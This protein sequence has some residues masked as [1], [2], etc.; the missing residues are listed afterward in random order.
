M[1]NILCYE[2]MASLAMIGLTAGGVLNMLLDPLFIFKFDMG[3]AGAGLSTAISE[4]VSMIILLSAF[5]RKKP[6]SRISLKYISLKPIVIKDIVLTGLPSL[7]RQ[8]L[9]SVSA[10]ALNIQAAAYGDACI[11]AMSIVSK[12]SNLI[13]SICIGIGQGFQPVSSFNYGAKKYSRVKQ[14]VKFTWAFGTAVVA[15]LSFVCFIFA[16]RIISLFRNEKSVLEIGAAAL[17]MVCIS[18]I[19]L[20]TIMVANMTF[21]SIGKSGRAFF[22]ACTQNG[23]LFIPLILILPNFAGVFGLEIA[24]PAAYVLAAAISLPFLISFLKKLPDD[25]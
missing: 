16:P 12:C 25:K 18:M 8:G 2:G 5:L 3:I 13:F 4:Y 24:Q 1:N 21:Q 14:G 6:Q 17:R 11:A 22:L 19:F 9:N 10:M 7:A 20:S 23:L 15:V